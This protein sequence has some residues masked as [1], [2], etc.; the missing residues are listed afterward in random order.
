MDN[1]TLSALFKIYSLSY[2]T[3][4]FRLRYTS[5]N[6]TYKQ[7]T[8]SWK[9]YEKDVLLTMLEERGCNHTF[10]ALIHTMV[11]AESKR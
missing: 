11:N 6:V 1:K 8:D 5:Q 2:R 3:I 10:I 7:R 9:D 4:G